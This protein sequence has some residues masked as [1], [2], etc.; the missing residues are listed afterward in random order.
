MDAIGSI[1]TDRRRLRFITWWI[2]SSLIVPTILDF[3]FLGSTVARYSRVIICLAIGISLLIN[4][5]LFLSS[6][7][8]GVE[9]II[10]TLGIFLIGSYSEMIRG[11][12]FTPNFATA[13]LI[14]I[15]IA[16]NIDLYGR[17]LAIFAANIY[18]LIIASSLAIL[19]RANPRGIY[20]SDE[21]YPVYLD[22]LGIPGRNYGIFAHP[23]GLGQ[24]AVLSL[25]LIIAL[26][27]NRYLLVLPVFCLI[28]SGSRTSITGLAVGLIVYSV[29][30]I[31]KRRQLSGKSINL[32]SPIVFGTFIFGILL[33]GSY[34]FLNYI[35]FLDPTALTNRAA[36][37]QTTATLLR[38]S[39]TF[40]IGWNWESRAI[41]SQ[42]IN[43][44]ATSAHNAILDVSISAGLVGLLLFFVLL[45]KAL[46]YFPNLDPAEKIILPAT[47][48]SGISESYVNLQYPTVQTILFLIIVLG[49]NR[50]RDHI[51]D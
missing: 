30:L 16:M 25:L 49:S 44:W 29:I 21:G 38:T 39:P 7:V 28:K 42:L 26:K 12:A 31:F 41:D 2:S 5:R 48:V 14:L 45:A 10:I 40:G 43:V 37:W 15:I 1:E 27:S 50:K 33:A 20:L 34:Q 3:A 17:V 6:K 9:T 8:A 23:N 51:H 32:E 24:V 18:V 19:L 4:S 35:G 11:G 47:L 36:I 13:F 46:A 22:F